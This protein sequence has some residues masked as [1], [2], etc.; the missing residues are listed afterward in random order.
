LQ[1]SILKESSMSAILIT[2]G[3]NEAVLCDL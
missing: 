3:E 2:A 1:A